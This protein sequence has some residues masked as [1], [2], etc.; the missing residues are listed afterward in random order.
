[1]K[2]YLLQS[3]WTPTFSNFSPSNVAYEHPHAKDL[4]L[5]ERE[6]KHLG[7]EVGV[8]YGLNAVVK[9]EKDVEDLL[10]IFSNGKA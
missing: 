9:T 1:M 4:V 8:C 3:G 6:D 10:R 7:V 5:F 2:T